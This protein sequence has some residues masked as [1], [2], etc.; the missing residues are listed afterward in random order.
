MFSNSFFSKSNTLW[1]GVEKY[2]RARNATD[3]N[4]VQ[5]ISIVFWITKATY[6]HSE[7]VILI[8]LPWEQ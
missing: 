4:T 6:I 7:Y 1:D 3:D 8:V 5:C 2:G